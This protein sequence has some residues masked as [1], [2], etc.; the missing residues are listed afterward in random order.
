[1]L[2]TKFGLDELTSALRRILAHF[3]TTGSNASKLL[4]EWNTKHRFH[5]YS[6]RWYRPPSPVRTLGKPITRYCS[7]APSGSSPSPAVSSVTS[8]P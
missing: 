4:V 8:L 1:M 3:R 6:L 2:R 5:M 7:L